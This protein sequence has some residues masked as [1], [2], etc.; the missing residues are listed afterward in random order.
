MIN[1]PPITNLIMYHKNKINKLKFIRIKFINPLKNN[2]LYNKILMI[3]KDS[4]FNNNLN[5]IVTIIFNKTKF[6]N[7]ILMLSTLITLKIYNNHNLH[8]KLT[9]KMK[10]L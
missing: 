4:I 1:I 6:F 5:L 2:Y 9:K 10:E 3:F 7:K 8:L